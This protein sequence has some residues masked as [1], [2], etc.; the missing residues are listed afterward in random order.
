[1]A[2]S[3]LTHDAGEPWWSDH[4]LWVEAF[5]VFNFAGLIGDIYLAHSENA[6]RR[7]SEYI[8]LVFSA[9]AAIVLGAIL[10]LR[11]RPRGSAIWRDVG[12]LVGWTSV[13]V[14][15]AGVVLHLDSQF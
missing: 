10:P 6:F 5:V 14:G 11:T 8:P 3:R 9:V 15:L 2:G 7:S 4:Q 13:L 1:M 12:Y